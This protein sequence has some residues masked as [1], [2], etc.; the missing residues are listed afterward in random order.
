[1]F[2]FTHQAVAA[3]VTPQQPRMTPRTMSSFFFQ[4]LAGFVGAEAEGGSGMVF[5][6]CR[7]AVAI[8]PDNAVRVVKKV[9]PSSTTTSADRANAWLLRIRH[10]A[11]AATE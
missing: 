2:R 3:A 10:F 9:W 7:G 5:M 11:K 1:M 6:V 4:V 8:G